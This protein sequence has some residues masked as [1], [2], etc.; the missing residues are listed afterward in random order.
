MP[1]TL[2]PCQ[3]MHTS[4]KHASCTKECQR[5]WSCLCVCVCMGACQPSAGLLQT[6]QTML[7]HTVAVQTHVMVL[8]VAPQQAATQVGQR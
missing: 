3:H 6:Q 7:I 2:V 1:E 4:T 8:G 5:H